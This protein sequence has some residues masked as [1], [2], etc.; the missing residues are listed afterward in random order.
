M[1]GCRRNRFGYG[2]FE[3]FIRT[4]VVM[5]SRQLHQMKKSSGDEPGLKMNFGVVIIQMD[6]I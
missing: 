2:H 6:R 3:T 1:E 4:Q 5:S